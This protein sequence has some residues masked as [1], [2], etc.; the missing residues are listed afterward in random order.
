M[1]QETFYPSPNGDEDNGKKYL[2]AAWALVT[3]ATLSTIV[4]VW[5]RSRLTRNM[6]WD[7]HNMIIGQSV[8]LVGLGL[9]TAQV[10]NGLGR[11]MYYLQPEQRRRFHLLGWLDWMQTF[12]AI[13]FTKIS[14]CVFLLRIKDDK[15]NKIFMYSLIG[16]N[17]VVTVI[18]CALFLSFC[19]PIHAYWDVGV[20]GI[21]FSKREIMATVA[22]QGSFSV[23]SDLILATTPLLFLR[24]LQI[25]LR[26]KILL[27]VLMGAG[28]ITA[29]C[30]LTRTVLSDRVL[31]PDITWSDLTTA[32]WRATEVNLGI[33]C[34]NA[35]IA[36][37]LYLWSK[38]RL[39]IL[40]PSTTT[41]LSGTP[42]H[43]EKGRNQKKSRGLW[44][45]SKGQVQ[46]QS[47]LL[48]H[49]KIHESET[50]YQ[51]TTTSSVEMGLPMQGY[52]LKDGKRHS[53]W[54]DLQEAQ[55]EVDR[56]RDVAGGVER[57]PP[58]PPEEAVM[59]LER[60]NV[61][62]TLEQRPAAEKS[63]WTTRERLENERGFKATRKGRGGI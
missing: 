9:V 57:V 30:S 50:S 35:P 40:H 42:I 18:S 61:E 49:Q 44:P 34:A 51:P 33:I 54:I 10:F 27:C 48:P 21:C 46:R 26:T 58:I 16:A 12:T 36:R 11:H 20:E 2:G 19:R 1:K 13:M 7:D 5:V 39:R 23:L 41:E 8:N 17:V 31:D 52:L 6:G 14:I 37:P 55:R 15:L 25:S 60:N 3:C 4:R 47:G 63:E 62:G 22:A 29:G 53:H 32:A 28:Y 59:R 43:Q 24:N 56:A 45:W 38:G